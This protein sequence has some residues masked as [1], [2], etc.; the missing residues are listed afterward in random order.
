M[1]CVV[2]SYHHLNKLILRLSLNK[3]WIYV[4]TTI[5]YSIRLIIIIF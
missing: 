1:S 4:S 3:I 5:N 2:I